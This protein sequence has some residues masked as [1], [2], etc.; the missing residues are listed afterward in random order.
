MLK[1]PEKFIE[2]FL[3]RTVEL[4]KKRMSPVVVDGI[5]IEHDLESGLVRLSN[6]N[7]DYLLEIRIT[8]FFRRIFRVGMDVEAVS[9]RPQVFRDIYIMPV[10]WANR[11][12]N[13]YEEN[14]NAMKQVMN[15][16]DIYTSNIIRRAPDEFLVQKILEE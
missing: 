4:T 10:Y 15:W 14:R 8:R 5:L 11:I 6:D 2:S 12:I 9:F 3:K 1:S 7:A 13:G 16:V